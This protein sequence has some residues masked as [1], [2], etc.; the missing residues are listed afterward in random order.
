MSSFINFGL[1]RLRGFCRNRFAKYCLVGG[2]G[3]IIDMCVLYLMADPKWLGLNVSLS[4]GFSAE[5]A[6]LTNF[7]LNE[8]W[9][10]RSPGAATGPRSAVIYRLL[11]F[12]A[13]CG[14][15]VIFAVA[16]VTLSHS[17]CGLHLM[18]ANALSIAIVTG[19]NFWMNAKFNWS[20][21]KK[22]FK[23]GMEMKEGKT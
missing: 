14:V 12:H 10:F 19:W 13:I 3:A 23:L 7:A 9:T 15:G 6:M 1:G 5:I 8:V 4:K 22:C 16:I 20:V 17:F 2:S 18:V 11:K 21:S